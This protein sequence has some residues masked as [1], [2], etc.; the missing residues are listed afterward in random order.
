MLWRKPID[1][2]LPK[3]RAESYP[4]ALSIQAQHAN[5]NWLFISI[6]YI[7]NLLYAKFNVFL[8]TVK[9]E[10]QPNSY[11]NTRTL[12]PVISDASNPTR[13]NA[14]A[15]NKT[16]TRFKCPAHRRGC[17]PMA[18][19]KALTCQH[20]SS[21]SERAQWE[22]RNNLPLFAATPSTIPSPTHS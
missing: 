8:S 10:T 3:Y 1:C 16:K 15:R 21:Q 11:H 14:L 19:E 17:R 13:L 22:V 4:M 9:L 12:Y 5:F 18:A 20:K 6:A 7:F 2:F